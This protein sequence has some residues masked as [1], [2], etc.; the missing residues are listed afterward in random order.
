[1]K[2]L[3]ILLSLFSLSVN[4]QIKVGDRLPNFSLQNIVGKQ[5][6]NSDFQNK[7][8]L[9]DFWASWC[10]PCRQA[11]KN[12]VK[13]Y[14]KSDKKKFEI[15]G[16]SVD[17]DKSKW[18]KAIAKDKITFTQLND[19]NGFDAKTAVRFGVEELPTQ[20]LFD[21]KGILVAINPTEQ[22]IINVLKQKK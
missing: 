14:D 3:L 15:I 13:L 5:I 12:L 18:K 11:N 8:V 20:Y 7:V 9:I 19:P 1:M 4:A 10:A 16:I 21:S 22:Q 6:S 2:K 17:I